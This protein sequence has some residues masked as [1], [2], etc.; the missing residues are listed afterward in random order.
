VERW[1]EPTFGVR[2]AV[3]SGL[4]LQTLMYTQMRPKRPSDAM[5]SSNQCAVR[6]Y[7]LVDEFLGVWD[8]FFTFLQP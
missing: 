5:I 3:L 6:M 1:L 8:A 4:E 2:T 7:L